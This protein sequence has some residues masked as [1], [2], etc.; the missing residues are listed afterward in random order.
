MQFSIR[1]LSGVD[2]HLFRELLAV[3]GEVFSD[4][5]A[6]LAAQPGQAYLKDLLG[7]DQFIALA[8]L[9]DDAVIGGLAA[10]ELKKFE[11]ER[12]EIYIYDLAVAANHRRRGVSP[13]PSLHN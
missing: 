11:Q 9:R 8:A 13:R 7:D 10:D 1:E 2:V 3:F 6:Y 5:N 4:E 12:S